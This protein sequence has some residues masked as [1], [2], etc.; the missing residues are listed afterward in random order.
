MIYAFYRLLIHIIPNKIIMKPIFKTAAL[1]ISILLS[2]NSHAQPG[3]STIKQPPKINGVIKA[4]T[5]ANVNAKIHANSNSV[6]GASK[7]HPKYDK[8]AQPKKSEIK[9]TDEA[10]KN[11]K[12]KKSKKK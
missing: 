2:Y 5:N 8:K 1:L 12:I 10:D 11:P 7:T 3:R 4:T 9:K 6:F